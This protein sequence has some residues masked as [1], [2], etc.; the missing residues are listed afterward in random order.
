MPEPIK[1][2][3]I[4]GSTGTVGQNTLDVIALHK[5]LYR[6]FALTANTNVEQLLE[7]CHRFK[8]RFAVLKNADAAMQL[9]KLMTD[10]GGKTTVLGGIEGLLEVA[11]HAECDY[12]MAAIVGA[13]GLEPTLA[14]V[15]S[16]K[17][18]LLANKEAL[19]MSGSLFMD[20][21]KSSGAEV[22]PI[23]SEHNAIFQCLPGA[24]SF[25]SKDIR[26]I[27]LTGSGGPLLREPLD[28]LKY[29]QPERA[30]AHPNWKM[31]KKISVDSATMM[32]KGLELIEANWLFDVEM[33]RIEVIIHPQSIVH[34][35]VEYRDGS[36][37]A[38]LGSPDMRTPIAHGLA[39]PK[40][41]DSGVASLDF[42]TI[43]QLQFESVDME[44]YPCLRLAMDVITA[45]GSL[46]TVLNA[47]NEVA[48]QAYLDELIC[49]T[50]IPIIIESVL[51]RADAPAA[52]SIEEILEI[53]RIARH[54]AGGMIDTAQRSH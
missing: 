18:V 23:D 42:S 51:E 27:L 54:S 20:A 30:C 10:Q 32:N 52:H 2:V 47:A 16:G 40:R 53:D 24:T 38:Q 46:P 43:G 7:Q 37:L 11:S 31:G 41:I 14:A 1:T 39:W 15:E 6:V 50:D 22:L 33:D 21:V 13:A 36:I 29:V 8:P 9:R 3:T 25:E 49:F 35:M 26:R 12:V 17:R 44:R 19:V 34:S 5:D 28:Q 45:G 48:V 4:L